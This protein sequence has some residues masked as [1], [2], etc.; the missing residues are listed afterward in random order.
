MKF[1]IVF[2]TE[3]KE[4]HLAKYIGKPGLNMLDILREIFPIL[5]KV[6]VDEIDVNS[7][8]PLSTFSK[9]ILIS[10]EE[11]RICGHFRDNTEVTVTVPEFALSKFIKWHL[12]QVYHT[13]VKKHF[14]IFIK[15]IKIPYRSY[16]T[17]KLD[18]RALFLAWQEAGFP[19]KW[20]T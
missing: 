17:Q 3:D 13:E 9:N 2:K 1:Y 20:K 19:L 8:C 6:K 7:R 14:F 5:N 15:E 16:C 12:E 4:K 18:V 10:E 11:A